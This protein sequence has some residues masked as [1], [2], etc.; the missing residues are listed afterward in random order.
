VWSGA[1]SSREFFHYFLRNE[2]HAVRSGKWKLRHVVG[3]NNK[4]DTAKLELYDLT[5]DPGE[6]RNIA[7]QH[8]DVVKRLTAAMAAMRAQLGDPN[9][10][11]QG[12]ERR[13]PAVSSDPRPLTTI[14]E[15]YPVIEPEY[16][17]NEAG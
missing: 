16:H 11:E 1:D 12:T 13:Q 3:N 10:G 2:L 8:P 6:S 17:L 9:F 7:D 14:E 5:E 15:D 4:V